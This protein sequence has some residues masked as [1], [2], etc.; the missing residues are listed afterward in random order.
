[1]AKLV[2]RRDKLASYRNLVALGGNTEITTDKGFAKLIEVHPATVSRVLT[3]QCAPGE[4]F[5]AG[6]LKLFGV[7]NFADLFAVIN[8]EEP[9]A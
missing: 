4:R 8:D 2:L 7:E 9:A 6:V 5:I 3:G 1:M